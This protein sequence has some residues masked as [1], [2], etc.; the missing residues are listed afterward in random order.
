M[1][2][3]VAPQVQERCLN[4]RL[5][6]I[7]RPNDSSGKRERQQVMTLVENLKRSRIQVARQANQLFVAQPTKTPKIRRAAH[8]L[9]A[10]HTLLTKPAAATPVR[11]RGASGR[12]AESFPEPLSSPLEPGS[13]T[14]KGGAASCARSAIHSSTES[15][16]DIATSRVDGNLRSQ[17]VLPAEYRPTSHEALHHKT[18]ALASRPQLASLASASSQAQ[19]VRCLSVTCR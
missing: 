18:T 10:P 19:S 2:P 13:N 16:W 14:T 5:R 12:S 7:P 17:S 8:P 4:D 11:P 3:G 6:L 9:N 15:G 1:S